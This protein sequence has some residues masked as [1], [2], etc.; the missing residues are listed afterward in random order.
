MG[1]LESAIALARKY[2]HGQYRK[3]TQPGM[4]AEEFFVHPFSVYERVSKVPGV[5]EAVQAA[6]VLH[7]VV[8]DTACTLQDIK[9][10]CG[11][12]VASLVDGLTNRSSVDPETKKLPRA[13]RKRI[14]RERLAVAPE[15]VRKIKL[16]DRA[17]N[18]RDMAGAPDKF[19]SIYLQESRQLYAVL[20]DADPVLAAEYEAAMSDL[21]KSIREY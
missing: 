21:E 13:E 7:D 18:L 10:H 2:H 17:Y 12:E 4:P 8:E 19:K 11:E 15:W 1:I 5:T 16:I 6:A 14:D 9:F 3:W 20:C